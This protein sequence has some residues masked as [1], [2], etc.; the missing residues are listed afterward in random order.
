MYC[1]GQG[2]PKDLHQAVIWYD[3]AANWA[4]ALAV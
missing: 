2:V 4:P 1:T 3:L